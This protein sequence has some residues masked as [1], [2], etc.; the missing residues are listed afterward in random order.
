MLREKDGVQ[1][2]E[3]GCRFLEIGRVLGQLELRHFELSHLSASTLQVPHTGV[4]EDREFVVVAPA[5]RH[6]RLGLQSAKVD[7]F[8]QLSD[9][10]LSVLEGQRPCGKR[11]VAAPS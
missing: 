4:V 11:P 5:K 3:N 8:D 2:A 9:P 1:P 7:R 10:D 6:E